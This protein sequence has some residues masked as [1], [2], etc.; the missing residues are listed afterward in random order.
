MKIFTKALPLALMA[1]F[2]NLQTNAQTSGVA[3]SYAD[4]DYVVLPDNLLSSVTGNFTIEMWVYWRGPSDNRWQRILDFGNSSQYMYLTPSGKEVA[5][6][7]S[8]LTFGITIFGDCCEKRLQAPTE[9]SMNTW[10]HIAITLDDANDMAKM[11]L[12]GVEV[13]SNN[14]TNLNATDVAA[15]QNWLGRSK[16][17]DAPFLDPY[18]NG[19]IDEFRISNVIRYTGNFT[20]QQAQFGTD[21]NTVALYHFNEGSGQTTADASANS[22]NGILG[23]TTASEASDPTWTT[24]SILPI[25]ILNL[26]AQKNT[27][28]IDLKWTASVTGNGGQ[29]IVERSTDGNIF[30]PIGSI[31]IAPNAGTSN[32][33]FSDR[34]FNSRKNYYRLKV[35]E[36]NAAVKYSAMVVVDASG[37]GMYSAYPTVTAS[38]VFVQVPRPTLIA[39]YNS[40]G[41]MVKQVQLQGSQ[42]IELKDLSKGVYQ[43]HFEGSS[44]TVRFIKQ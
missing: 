3:L 12:D 21:A 5:T 2:I 42:N 15:T 26:S 44:E 43:I 4:D 7:T 31:H 39:I 27:S 25:T 20:P 11:Y 23:A 8:R 16:F 22:F 34:Q 24:G 41:A 32:Y 40:N 1:L 38:Q 13:A 33:S 17:S 35:A 6:N 18:F 37:K 28:S 9:L 19:I 29:F 36:V 14:A 30:Q 10:H